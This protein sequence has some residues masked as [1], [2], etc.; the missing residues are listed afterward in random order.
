MLR[1]LVR[2]WFVV[3][4][5]LMSIGTGC[6]QI[7]PRLTPLARIDPAIFV[8]VDG[9]AARDAYVQSISRQV[10]IRWNE[11]I[12]SR[13]ERNFALPPEKTAVDVKFL[14]RSDGSI[15]IIEVSG[16]PGRRGR[17]LR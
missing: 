2:P 13:F 7:R 11:L 3:A 1:G 15:S 8:G 9:Q 12:R 14:L 16:T 4:V 5:V 10:D 6:V 17:T